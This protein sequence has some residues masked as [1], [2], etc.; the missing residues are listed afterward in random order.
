MKIRP[1]AN[2]CFFFL[3][4]FSLTGS[5]CDREAQDDDFKG[6]NGAPDNKK[7]IEEEK[8][9][10]PY[11]PIV[12]ASEPMKFWGDSNPRNE[13]DAKNTT[14]ESITKVFQILVE[15]DSSIARVV[16][17]YRGRSTCKSK[18][19]S[20]N[21][22]DLT[23]ELQE[24]DKAPVKLN[25]SDKEV[26]FQVEGG[27]PYRL[28]IVL[29]N[30]E[31][32]HISDLDYE[33]EMQKQVV[34]EAQK[35]EKKADTGDA[36]EE[37]DEHAKEKEPA[38]N[39]L[40]HLVSN[41][42]LKLQCYIRKFIRNPKLTIRITHPTQDH[43]HFSESVCDVEAEILD[44][45]STSSTADGLRGLSKGVLRIHVLKSSNQDDCPKVGQELT[46]KYRV[47]QFT[48]LEI[49]GYS[50]LVNGE[51]YRNCQAYEK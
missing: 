38:W 41:G 12:L 44:G 15:K 50:K 51:K 36:K 34:P 22:S 39:R 13:F 37:A 47:K 4:L 20:L 8:A 14:A 6:D 31:H 19:E 18:A 24:G 33:F 30:E 46:I 28:T 25:W 27:V 21:G 49:D 48:E 26:S 43:F 11:L 16:S 23:A 35:Q 5:E 32:C 40:F 10:D 29:N 42:D 3:L 17:R 7:H 1:I 2:F 9:T 45:E